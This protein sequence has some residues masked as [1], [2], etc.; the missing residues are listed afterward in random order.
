MLNIRDLAVRAYLEANTLLM[1]STLIRRDDKRP[2]M[3][4]FYPQGKKINLEAQEEQNG[5]G[6]FI[7]KF[8]SS[9][10]PFEVHNHPWT[11]CAS[12]IL[13]NSYIETRYKW[14]WESVKNEGKKVFLS[15][16]K[17]RLLMPNML[18]VITHDVMHQVNLVDDQP[19][20]T[21]FIH[22]PRVSTWGFANIASG[23]YREIT[24]RTAE[25]PTD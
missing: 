10:D 23:E 24:H 18:N 15:K 7:H 5:F 4:R 12:V 25:R 6:W 16:P 14:G 22:G 3:R 20:W 19:V 21:L 1:E 13:L 11:W 2:Y 8:L 9:D 17:T